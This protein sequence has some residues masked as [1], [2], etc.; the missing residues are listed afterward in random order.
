MSW[1]IILVEL[2]CDR[3]EFRPAKVIYR[4]VVGML[5]AKMR[6]SVTDDS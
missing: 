5:Q 1:S 3:R 4:Q 2:G 6:T